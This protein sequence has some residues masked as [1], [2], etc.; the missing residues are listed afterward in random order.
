M[1]H[2]PARPL[3]LTKD[4][5]GRPATDVGGLRG[6]HPDL[7][8][9]SDMAFADAMADEWNTWVTAARAAGVLA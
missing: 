2:T 1:T 9:V 5:T 4:P 6:E 7:A 3:A 8:S